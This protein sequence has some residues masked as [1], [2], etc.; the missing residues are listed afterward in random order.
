MPTIDEQRR[1]ITAEQRG[2]LDEIW[3]HF[4]TTKQ[5]PSAWEMNS[6]HHKPEVRRILQPLNDSIVVETNAGPNGASIY[7]L[8]LLGALMTSDGRAME[9]LIVRYLE[10][11][12]TLYQTNPK[13]NLVEGFEIQQALHLSDDETILLGRLVVLGSLYG[14]G[15]GIFERNGNPKDWSLG[16]LGAV[17][18][19]PRKGAL[20]GELNKLIVGRYRNGPVFMDDRQSINYPP[21]SAV[22]FR[23][24]N[25]R[26]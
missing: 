2:L 15:G 1:Q 7:Q 9:K 6:R 20:D 22:G 13:K 3:S 4:L 25:R 11:L 24:C 10:H 5:W 19:F 26:V 17:E 12:R 14:A 21:K 23:K 8:Q 16:I 18:D